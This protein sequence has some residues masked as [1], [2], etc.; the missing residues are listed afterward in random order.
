M[1]ISVTRAAGRPLIITVG[2]PFM[3]SKGMGGCGT[4]VSG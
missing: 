3:I 4:G 1:V 2:E